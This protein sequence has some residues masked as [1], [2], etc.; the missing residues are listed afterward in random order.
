MK[1]CITSYMTSLEKTLDSYWLWAEIQDMLNL[2][3]PAYKY[4]NTAK[5]IKLNNK[6]I[7]L[8]K[9]TLPQK[10]SHVQNKLTDLSGYLP[11]RYAANALH[12][13]EHIF[14]SSKMSLYDRFEYRYVQNIKFVNIKKFLKEFGIKT[15]KNS[16]L[17]L[18][19]LKNLEIIPN[20]RF[21]NLGNRYGLVVYD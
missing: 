20:S 19:L 2:S 10:Y 17:H 1:N 8:Q 15:D 14:T 16:L 11:I 3:N 5:H 18:G 7:F 9:N 6:Y 4:W 12:V 13:N 21:Y